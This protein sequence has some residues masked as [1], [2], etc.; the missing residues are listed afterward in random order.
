M[1]QNGSAAIPAAETEQK[2]QMSFSDVGMD[3][4]KKV[5]LGTDINSLT[6]LES[7]TLLYELQ[8]KARG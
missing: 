3:D 4:V 7:M 6:P 1:L 8:R 2:T 5:L